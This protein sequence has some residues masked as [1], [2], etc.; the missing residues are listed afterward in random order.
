MQKKI[1]NSLLMLAIFFMAGCASPTK[2]PKKRRYHLLHDSMP[3]SSKTQEHPPSP[4]IPKF[5]P[6]SRYGNP[7]T[8][9]VFKQQYSVLA[10]S[11]NYNETGTASWYGQKFH[12]YKTSSGEVYD[13]FELTAAHKTLPLPTYAEVTNIKTG[14]KI[15]VKINDRGPFHNDRLIDLSYA[16]AKQ[17]EIM[18]Q[19]TAQ[20][21]IKALHPIKNLNKPLPISGHYRQLAAFKSAKNANQFAQNLRKI[22]KLPI[23]IEQEKTNS[24]VWYK[25]KAG[26]SQDPLLLVMLAEMSASI[27]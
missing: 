9:T 18:Q 1:L 5:E 17:L 24:S 6:R 15:I 16:A 10:S 22:T 2:K 11:K 27:R 19:G 12:G 13:M 3:L 20:V 14:K 4:V 26:P 25:V 23:N 21:R 8:Y 7:K